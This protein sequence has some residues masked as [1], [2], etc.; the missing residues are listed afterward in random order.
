MG[1]IGGYGI[2]GEMVEGDVVVPSP[3]AIALAALGLVIAAPT[4]AWRVAGQIHR[5]AAS[6]LSIGPL[7]LAAPMLGRN[8][9][10][11]LTAR[12]LGLSPIGTPTLTG[13]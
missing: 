4:I 13:R 7:A 8:G 2:G 12:S 10:A 11:A 6:V 9:T 5:L 1:P 3:T